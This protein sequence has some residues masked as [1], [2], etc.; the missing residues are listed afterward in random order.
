[1]STGTSRSIHGCRATTPS[2]ACPGT[3]SGSAVPRPLHAGQAQER[4]EQRLGDDEG[5]AVELHRGVGLGGVHRD[6]EVG[7]QG[8][9]RGRPDH[10]R[11]RPAADRAGDLR[12]HRL[13]RELHVDRR[14]GLVLVLHL[15]L[16][17]RGLAVHAPVHR[18]E[19][20]V[21]E[22]AAHEPPELARDHRL[23]GGRHRPVG[24]AP[25]AEHA[26]APELLALDVDELGRVLAAAA[27]LLHGIH[28]LP[29]VHARLVEAELL[30]DLVLDRQPVA[31]PARHVDRV[32]AQ[33]GAR[34]HDEILQ[35]LVQR[36]A[37]VDVAVRV[38]RSVVEDPAADGSPRPAGSARRCPSPPSARA[39]PAPSWAGW[40]S[41][42]RRSWAG[43]ACPCNP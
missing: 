20:L 3:A 30:V 40:P 34:L 8:P 38:R 24:I 42:E 15:G 35:D 12:G 26:E 43:L 22:V 7:R 39:I 2:S 1:M 32:V 41:W 36:G 29:H 17:E 31:I 19:A 13:D 4:L 27:A 5:L 9:R 37:H 10:E 11:D 28:G 18:L 6:R 23:V 14:R 21:H 33:H 25:V 16:G